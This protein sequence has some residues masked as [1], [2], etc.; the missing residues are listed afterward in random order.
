MTEKILYDR[1]GS[2]M[3]GSAAS[4]EEQPQVEGQRGGENIRKL[5]E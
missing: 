1:A 5:M 4:A 3:E 2:Q